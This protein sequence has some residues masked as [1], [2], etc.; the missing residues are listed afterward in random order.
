[1]K[2]ICS[3]LFWCRISNLIGG[4]SIIIASRNGLLS[5]VSV[6]LTKMLSGAFPNTIM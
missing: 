1:M 4:K 2:W 3:F 5:Q 6:K